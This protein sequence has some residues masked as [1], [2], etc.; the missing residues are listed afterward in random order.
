LRELLAEED[1]QKTELQRAEQRSPREFIEKLLQQERAKRGLQ[2]APPPHDQRN[3]SNVGMARP[4]PTAPAARQEL[5]EETEPQ[6]W[7]RLVLA[8]GVELHVRTDQLEV[9]RRIINRL[10]DVGRSEAASNDH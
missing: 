1:R 5:P 9:K 7:Q 10:C 4:A 8:P 2:N 6:I 3:A